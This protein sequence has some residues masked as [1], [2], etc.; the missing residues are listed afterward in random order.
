MCVCVDVDESVDARQC[1]NN[2]IY[3]DLLVRVSVPVTHLYLF[4]FTLCLR[5]YLLVTLARGHAIEWQEKVRKH[6]HTDTN[7]NIAFEWFE[8]VAL[9]YF[10]T[11]RTEC[12]M[13]WWLMLRCLWC[14]LLELFIL[15][16]SIDINGKE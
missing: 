2:V 7:I 12:N 9:V 16:A 14:L 4:V 11:R 6:T 10:R 5:A 1:P 8:C 13:W 3:R 15:V